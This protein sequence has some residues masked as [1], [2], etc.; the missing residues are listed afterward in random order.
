[1]TRL[2]ASTRAPRAP[3]DRT[4]LHSFQLVCG[5]AHISEIVLCILRAGNASR[6]WAIS[7]HAINYPLW[8]DCGEARKTVTGAAKRLRPVVA[9]G[10]LVGLLG[11]RSSSEDSGVEHS[12]LVVG[13]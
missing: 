13:Q 9:D 8:S 11:I 10:A 2:L 12:L 5:I 7:R 4:I 3:R 1:M 6:K